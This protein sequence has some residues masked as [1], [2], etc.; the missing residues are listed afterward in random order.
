M[1]IDEG[2]VRSPPKSKGDIAM[3]ITF[4]G[5]T[6]IEAIDRLEKKAN[7]ERLFAARIGANPILASQAEKANSRAKQ[8]ID[9]AEIIRN[10]EGDV[11]MTSSDERILWYA[12]GED[13]FTFDAADSLYVATPESDDD[14]PF[15]VV[16]VE[17]AL[18]AQKTE[19]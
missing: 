13:E 17:G 11:R 19:F 1:V 4:T 16:L 14:I 6:K 5:I 10:S 8:C 2:R 12:L 18:E 3:K 9:I 7:D 15:E